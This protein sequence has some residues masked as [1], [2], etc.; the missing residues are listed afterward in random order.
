MTRSAPGRVAIVFVLATIGCSD[1]RVRVPAAQIADSVGVRLI[2]YDL[3]DADVPAYRTVAEHDLQ[4]GEMDGTPEHTFSRI[5]DLALSSD[6]EILVSDGLS[7]ELRLFD[8]GGRY[9]RTIGGAGDGP[10]EFASAPSIAGLAGDTAYVFDLRSERLT[11][12]DLEGEM[13]EAITLGSESVPRPRSLLRLTDGS[14]L[15]TSRW[16][17]PRAE[18]EFYEPRPELDSIVVARLD[19]RGRLMDTIRVMPDRVMARTVQDG[20]GGAIRLL[21]ADAPYSARAAVVA[22][23][24]RPIVGHGSVFALRLL[25]PAGAVEAILRVH[26]VE[27][28]ATADEIRAHQ[29]ARLR[30]Q[31]GDRE[32]DPMTR[33]LN[34]DFLP[35]RLPAFGSVVVSDT[36][37]LWIS[38]TEYDLSEGLDWLVFSASG[39]LRGL[40][41]TP[42]ELRVRAIRDDL[43]L[44]FV[45]DE[46]DV[47]YVRRYPLLHA[48]DEGG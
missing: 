38:L 13:L 31:A 25:Q 35:D 22:D 33:R 9:L 11:S 48:G 32:V 19:A 27:H 46:L 6:G 40:V 23:G 5:D 12:F 42:P 16:M 28:S 2:T 7:Q 20:G 37:D 10:G 4:I 14:Y 36:G 39:E 21:Q 3:G 30:E 43:I 29:E 44:G 24:V 45:L 34:L 15:S 8:A 1:E 17:V 18:L 26:G 47:P 41:W